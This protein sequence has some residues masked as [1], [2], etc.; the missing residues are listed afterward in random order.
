ME[1]FG[2]NQLNQ[3]N[4]V[5]R[6][7]VPLIWYTEKNKALLWDGPA[8]SAWPNVNREKISDKITLRNILQNKGF[9]LCKCQRHAGQGKAKETKEIWQLNATH[10]PGLDSRPKKDIIG[11]DG[12]IQMLFVDSMVTLYQ[13]LRCRECFCLKELHSEVSRDNKALCLQ[14]PLKLLRKKTK[15]IHI[16]AE[17]M[18]D[19]W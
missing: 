3:L 6:H 14:L 18:R 13:C 5:N 15:Y 17:R 12:K 7:H 11:T 2:K 1:K 9:S 4:R 10:N 16:Y 8:K 19:M